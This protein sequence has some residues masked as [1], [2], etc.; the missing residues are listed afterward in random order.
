[1]LWLWQLWLCGG[2]MFFFLPVNLKCSYSIRLFIK[3]KQ[4]LKLT[5]NAIAHQ[6]RAY[7]FSGEQ[8]SSTSMKLISSTWC[9]LLQLRWHHKGPVVFFFTSQ[10][11]VDTF[12]C[13]NVP[14]RLGMLASTCSLR[15]CPFGIAFSTYSEKHFREKNACTWNEKFPISFITTTDETNQQP[16]LLNIYKMICFF[17]VFTPISMLS[18]VFQPSFFLFYARHSHSCRLLQ[19][20]I[21]L[22]YSQ[23]MEVLSVN[24]DIFFVACWLSEPI[25]DMKTSNLFSGADCITMLYIPNIMKPGRLEQSQWWRNSSLACGDFKYLELGSWGTGT[26]FILMGFALQPRKWGSSLFCGE[27]LL[28]RPSTRRWSL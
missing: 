14:G 17:R 5:Q 8:H 6:K 21:F 9:S 13:D 27:A 16:P 19:F 26:C 24:T 10:N 3:T 22:F 20:V 15:L 28:I 12:T 4:N 1:M 11:K 25:M 2:L 23:A 18:F 7:C